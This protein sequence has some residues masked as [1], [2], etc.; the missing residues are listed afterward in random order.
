M[1]RLRL[2]NF[3]KLELSGRLLPV[4]FNFFHLGEQRSP[5]ATL[6]TLLDLLLVP[7]EHDLNLSI[8]SVPNPTGQAGRGRLA[9][10]VKSKT[11]ILHFSVN[12]DMRPNQARSLCHSSQF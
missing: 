9:V 8:V 10:G 6:D 11:D 3:K 7:L 2:T 4:H 12:P 1:L 5:P